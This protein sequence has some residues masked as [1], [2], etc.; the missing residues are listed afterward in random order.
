MIKKVKQRKE[1]NGDDYSYV[2]VDAVENLGGELK[3]ENPCM[4]VRVTHKLK[5]DFDGE[6]MVSYDS[7]ILEISKEKFNNFIISKR[8]DK[9]NKIK[10]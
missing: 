2:S 1:E 10:N 9:I 6:T 4:L 8:K 3:S 5:Y 7:D